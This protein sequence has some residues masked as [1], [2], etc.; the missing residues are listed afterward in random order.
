MLAYS[1]RG[2]FVLESVDIS[3]MV[4]GTARLLE[5]LVSKKATLTV[6]LAPASP[7]IEADA[8][9][10]RQVLINLATNASDA[11]ADRGG[12]IAT[13]VRWDREVVK[14]HRRVDCESLR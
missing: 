6:D 14:S 2:Q 7:R 9:Q 10:I 11:V 12:E 5:S 4:E 13:E 8:G 3:H 1:G